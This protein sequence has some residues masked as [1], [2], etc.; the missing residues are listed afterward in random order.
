MLDFLHSLKMKAICEEDIPTNFEVEETNEYDN[1]AK[2]HQMYLLVLL[3]KVILLD[4]R[5]IFIKS[6]ENSRYF[7]NMFGS[8]AYCILYCIHQ[9]FC[10]PVAY[11]RRWRSSLANY[12]RMS[13]ELGL[14]PT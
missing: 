4:Y 13:A 6:M 9:C 12:D 3:Q 8:H 10:Q 1:I 5:E 2:I 11:G 14:G 7:P